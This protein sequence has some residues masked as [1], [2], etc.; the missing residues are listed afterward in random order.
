MR[1]FRI[2]KLH[3]L[4]RRMK[5]RS[6]IKGEL[7]QA[8]GAE[9]L[10]RLEID[11]GAE[12]GHFQRELEARLIPEKRSEGVDGATGQDLRLPPILTSLRKV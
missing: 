5:Y 3:K 2:K 7:K 11:I 8:G 4:Y 10:K 1:D 12:P 6:W 9:Y